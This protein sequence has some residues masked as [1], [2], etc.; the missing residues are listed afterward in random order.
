MIYLSGDLHFNHSNI[1]KY[2]NRPFKNVEEMNRV[3]IDNWNALIKF[4]D[5]VYHLGDFAFG[6]RKTITYS[7]RW[8]AW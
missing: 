1:I 2:C 7:C 6:N 5:T 4:D 8:V 3:I